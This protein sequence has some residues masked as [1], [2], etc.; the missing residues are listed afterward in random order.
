MKNNNKKTME[1]W[2]NK[3]KMIHLN[4]MI[5]LLC[6]SIPNK[7]Y[8][9]WILTKSPMEQM[10]IL[11]GNVHCLLVTHIKSFTC[12]MS[13]WFRWITVDNSRS[14]HKIEFM[15]IEIGKSCPLNTYIRFYSTHRITN[16]N[17]LNEKSNRRLM[18]HALTC[19]D[20]YHCYAAVNALTRHWI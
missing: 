4:W 19:T 8:F 13:H 18:P 17:F 14:N 20:K 7:F 12:R 15:T 6:L 2:K 3:M 16:T 11:A 1:K 9:Q 10:A 5:R